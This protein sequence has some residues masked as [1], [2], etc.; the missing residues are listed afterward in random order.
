MSVQFTCLAVF[1]SIVVAV[2]GCRL[3][4]PKSGTK[5]TGVVIETAEAGEAAQTVAYLSTIEID[6]REGR[7][8]YDDSVTFELVACSDSDWY[9]VSDGSLQFSIPRNL[10]SNQV[11]WERGD[12]QYRILN[13]LRSDGEL[14]SSRDPA[15][16]IAV[17]ALKTLNGRQ[18]TRVYVYSQKSGLRGFLISHSDGNGK[19]TPVFYWRD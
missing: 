8:K 9:C 19:L 13:E 7:I 10:R 2:S 6:E 18:D 3:T 16:E 1:F 11:S 5:F 12:V 17:L 14:G 15:R 4:V